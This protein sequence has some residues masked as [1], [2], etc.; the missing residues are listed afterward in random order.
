MSP[1]LTVLA[2]VAL[3]LLAPALITA[4]HR[5][6]NPREAVTLLTSVCLFLLLYSLH[7]DVLRGSRPA[8]DLVE[9]LP[10]LTIGFEVEPLGMLF[11]LLASFLWIV[12]SVY[13]IGYL[14]SH[15]EWR[16][17]SYYSY[18]AVALGSAM[19]IAFAGNLFTLFI[20]YELLTLSTYPLVTHAGDDVAREAGRMY[21]GY[22]LGTSVIL[23]LLALVWTWSLT[24]TLDFR[25]GGILEGAVT[26]GTASI[27]LVLFIFGIGKAAVMPFHLWLP[28][29]M[30]APTPVSALL[31]AV[32]VVKAGVFTILKVAIYIF[33]IDFL[34]EIPATR[35]LMY[36]AAATLLLAA[37]VALRQD[38]L[39]LRLA[40]STISHLSYVVLGTLLATPLGIVGGG[41][42]IVMHAFAKITLF[43]CAGAILVATHKT[44]VSEM[45]GLGRRMPVTMGAFFIASLSLIGLPPLGG[46]WSKWFLALGTLDS[47]QLVMLGVLLAGAMLNIAYL[48]PIPMRA[49]FSSECEETGSSGS[50][51]A[52]P[53][54]VAALVLT[55]MACV[56]LFFFPEPVY[57]LMQLLVQQE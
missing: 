40:W 55:A 25:A 26:P 6:P 29:A 34:A 27:L 53:A 54:C 10:G 17:T 12:T 36:V 15:H 52:P 32:A 23:L 56:V 20:F 8:I 38:N 16:Q 24:G 4:L 35:W 49:F 39:K 9:P 30:V 50:L 48:L 18:F 21:L 1:E 41:M 46:F 51:H 14:R 37:I 11:A 7:A 57:R 31:H 19:G 42:H 13:S 45:N 22:L 44:Q 5:W 3:P 33:G 28:A 43:F 47:Q 2:C